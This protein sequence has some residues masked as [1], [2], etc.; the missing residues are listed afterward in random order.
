M[1]RYT[2]K[3]VDCREEFD[4]FHGIFDH[5]EGCDLCS[6]TKV[7][8]VPQMPHIRREQVSKGGKVGEETKRAIE[9]NKALLREERKK[10]V[11]YKD[12]N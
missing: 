1:P 2:Y 4:V 3:C 8:R 11:E 6:S 5:C 9:E 7:A 12:G 10:R